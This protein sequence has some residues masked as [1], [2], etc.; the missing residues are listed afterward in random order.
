MPD[1]KVNLTD[2]CRRCLSKLIIVGNELHTIRKRA[3]FLE[4]DE[5]QKQLEYL[6]AGIDATRDTL[7]RIDADDIPY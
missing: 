7:Q 5:V 3:P 4:L 1:P 2:L 6:E